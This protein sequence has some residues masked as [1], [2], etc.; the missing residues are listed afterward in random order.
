M[1]HGAKLG[2]LTAC[3]FWAISFIATKVA[4]TAAPPLTVVTLRLV[5]S[6]ACFI[7]W[8]L[9][10][11]RPLRW[12][13]WHNVRQ[14]FVLSLFGTGLH[15]GIQTIGLQYTSASNASIYAVTGPIS[16]SLIAAIFL[17][18]RL[19]RLKILGI[20]LALVGVLVVTGLETL[21]SFELQAYL[22]GDLLVFAS[23]VMWALFTIYGK[24]L[25][26]AMGALELTAMTT[27]IGAL[28]MLPLGAGEIYLQGFSLGEI[29]SQAWL[30]IAFLGVTCSFLATLLYFMAL[31]RSESQKVG[32]YL[33]TIPPMTYAA[34]VLT[35]GETLGLN[36]LVGSLLVLAGVTL[37]ERG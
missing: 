10:T 27:I 19:T 11:R 29:S 30:A 17:G 32:V 20:S 15:Y 36:L 35:L 37:T 34:A 8:F 3:F 24:K 9:I 31:A 13:S 4:L 7:S 14:L 5:I 21:I 12:G 2:L 1:K 23:I 26:A 22:M 33:Y 16:I 28:W 18:E 25:S 6:A